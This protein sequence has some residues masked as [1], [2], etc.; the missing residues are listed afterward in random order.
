MPYFCGQ[1]LYGYLDG[2]IQSLS[3]FIDTIHLDTI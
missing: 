2:T 1:D 3:P